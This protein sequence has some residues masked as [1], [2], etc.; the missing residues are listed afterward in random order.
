MKSLLLEFVVLVAVTRRNNFRVSTGHR[1]G[2]AELG[3]F[4]VQTLDALA[5]SVF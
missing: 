2:E 5:K 3:T 4:L 1:T